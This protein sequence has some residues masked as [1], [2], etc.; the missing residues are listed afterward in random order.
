M[1]GSHIIPEFYLKQF[2]EPSKRGKSKPGR[3]WVY[4]RGRGPT[5]RGTSRQGKENGYFEYRKPD[6]TWDASTEMDL[7]NVERKCNDVLFCAKFDTF[8]WPTG[9]HGK[10]A[11][12]A[13]LLFSRATQRRRLT[14]KNLEKT[15]VELREADDDDDLLTELAEVLGRR[16]GSTVSRDEVRASI[17]RHVEESGTADGRRNAFLDG[18]IANARQVAEM[19]LRKQPWRILRPPAHTEFVTT[20]N[21]L[22][23]FVPLASGL[24]H[25]GYGFRKPIAAA[26]F[27][28]ARDACLL[29]GDVW[30]VPSTLYLQDLENLTQA[31]VSV[32]DRYVYSRTKLEG[33][34]E[35]VQ[36]YGGSARYGEN[37]FVPLGLEIPSAREFLR[38]HFG[39]GPE[40]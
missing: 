18:L 25:P 24:L 9:S 38:A 11:F 39:L 29:M 34:D 16:R 40:S 3:V 36:K 10:L 33:V 32:S 6:G 20:D 28:L 17:L 26:A 35:V 21:P 1:V 5:P 4:E 15:L 14:E 31:F 37:A 23:T 22:I 27:P 19:L 30:Q 12:Y 2:A 7:A 8:L 13:A